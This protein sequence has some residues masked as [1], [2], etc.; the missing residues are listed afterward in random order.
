MLSAE[1]DGDI[2]VKEPTFGRVA[3]QCMGGYAWQGSVVPLTDSA[4]PPAACAGSGCP[5]RRRGL[6]IMVISPRSSTVLQRLI[7]RVLLSQRVCQ[8]CSVL[9]S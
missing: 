4:R 3:A 5:C 7:A 1:M 2:G 6:P 9:S 8:C